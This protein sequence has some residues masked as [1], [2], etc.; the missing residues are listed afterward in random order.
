MEAALTVVR[1]DVGEK[2][3]NSLR[4]ELTKLVNSETDQVE[5]AKRLI[6]SAA[7]RNLYITLAGLAAL[8]LVILV[9]QRAVDHSIHARDEL[10]SQLLESKRSLHVTLM[11]IGDGVIATDAK[12]NVTLLNPVASSLIG[13][14]FD[15]AAGLPIETIFRIVN[16]Q[17]R[18]AVENPVSKVLANGQIA[19]LANHTVLIDKQ[20]HETP[21]EDSGAP[22]RDEAGRVQ[23]AVLV[24]R[25]IR[26]RRRTELALRQSEQRFRAAAEAMGD[27]IW[28]TNASG[29]M[30]SE[31]PGWA[32]FTG[33]SF[34]EYRGFGWTGAIHPDDRSGA[35]DAWRRAVM[36]RQKFLGEHRLQ[37]RDG[38]FR[39]CSVCAV[40]VASEGGEVR[41]WVG[42]HID[43]T[44]DRLS[45]D[46]IRESDERFRGLATAFS[47]LVWSTTADGTMEYTNAI[48]DEYAGAGDRS[49]SHSDVWRRLLDPADLESYTT[50]WQEAMESGDMFETQC[51]LKRASDGAYRWFLCRAMPVRGRDHQIVRWLGACLDI[52]DQMRDASELRQANE[53]LQLSNADLEQFAYAAS[54]DLQ[55]PLR[56]ISLYTQLLRDEYENRL[57]DTA[58]S[59]IGFAVT[60][61]QRMERLLRD[62]LAYSQVTGVP[63]SKTERTDAAAAL[64]MALDNLEALIRK[65]GAVIRTGELPV[66][67]I[68]PLHLTQLFQNL[69]GNA[70]KYNGD[71]LPQ[72]SIKAEHAQDLWRFS[73]KDNGI[74][75]EP[76]YVKQVFGVFKR[77]H[78]QEYEGTGI[79]LAICQRIVE[80][81]GGRIWLESTPGRGS[82]FYFTLRG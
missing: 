34:E 24:F 64:R 56:M 7:I 49:E 30:E 22:I 31:Q 51:R 62:L 81:N 79:G 14:T 19:G 28:T 38:V 32:A 78:G 66:V 52:D 82:T 8:A 39:M 21:V 80:R 45:H 60:G 42:V 61:A 55:E 76:Q 33:R 69:V 75:V 5:Q 54:H 71:R 50:R 48:W 11:S 65:T 68:A 15:D 9:L 23:G 46:R 72:V 63:A 41:E 70:L 1:T 26:E 16:E 37:R 36:E 35:V 47:Q 67:S 77:L 59:Y 29:E 4:T 58:R 53:A 44:E 12:G 13:W 74:G 43:I 57:D 17:T 18:S 25:D 27:V 6:D 10:A 20:G 2:A 3:M 73:V 40:P